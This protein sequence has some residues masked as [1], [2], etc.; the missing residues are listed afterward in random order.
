[1]FEPILTRRCALPRSD[2]I[3]VY[4]ADDGYKALRGLSLNT[5]TMPVLTN[6]GL[7]AVQRDFLRLRQSI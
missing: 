7:S 2:S 1:M 6:P 3:D 5:L 4:L